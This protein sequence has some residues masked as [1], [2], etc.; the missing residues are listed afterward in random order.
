MKVLP[1]TVVISKLSVTDDPLDNKSRTDVTSIVSGAIA[2]ARGVSASF[3]TFLHRRVVIVDV[4]LVAFD[5]E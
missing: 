3:L 4:Y 5:I 2:I 1:G